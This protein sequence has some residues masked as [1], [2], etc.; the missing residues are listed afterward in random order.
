MV[1]LD[2]HPIVAPP[3]PY[4][5]LPPPT[6]APPFPPPTHGNSTATHQRSTLQH[7]TPLQNPHNTTYC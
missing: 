7:N 3:T 4:N 1:P 6:I 2:H 5:T